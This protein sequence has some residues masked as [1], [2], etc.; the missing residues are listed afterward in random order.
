M[1]KVDHLDHLVLTVADI[2][3]T[4]KFYEQVMG[5]KIVTFGEGRK[6]MR[7]GDQKINIHEAG[8]EYEPK[9]NSTTP[10]SADLC[11]ITNTPI[12][13]VLVHLQEVQ[14]P[15]IDGPV[16]RTGAVGPILSVYFHDPDK[17]LIEVS[18][19]G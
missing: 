1:L 6:A 8:N 9:A 11:F 4:C 12:K 2:E 14:V 5:M 19:S 13:E 18:N 7:F 17:N 16:E 15:V 3:E 10:G